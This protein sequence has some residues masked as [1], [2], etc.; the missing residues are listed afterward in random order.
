VDSPIAKNVAAFRTRRHW[1]QEALAAATKLSPRTIQR[2]ERGEP[3]SVETLLSIAGALD[4]SVEDL[5]RDHDAEQLRK[6]Q[7]R[8]LTI[9]LMLVERAGQLISERT[10]FLMFKAVDVSDDDALDAVA[11]L[12]Q[13]MKDAIDVW[14]EI[15]PI[16]RR[17]FE[18]DTQAV[19]DT[20]EAL[21]LCVGV[22]V[23]HFRMAKD[24]EGTAPWRA[25]FVIVT[26]RESFK[27]FA[28]W[29]R[30]QGVDVV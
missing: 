21:G 1:T 17:K 19:L 29:D 3:A 25:L 20:V 5:K 7:N 4:V 8:F 9:P 15:E 28:V 11:E 18:R 16:A 23:T 2:I 13:W 26:P 6:L 27:P 24:P 12:E 22:G 30:S 10:H 14:S